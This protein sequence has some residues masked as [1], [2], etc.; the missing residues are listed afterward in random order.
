MQRLVHEALARLGF[1]PDRIH[2]E[3]MT[4]NAGVNPDYSMLAPIFWSEVS[5]ITGDRHIGLHIAEA[6]PARLLDEVVLLMYMSLDLREALNRLVRFRHLLSGGF[7][8]ALHSRPQRRDA[9]LVLDL[10]YPGFGPLRQ[11]AESVALLMVKLLALCTDDKFHL[12][13]LEFR[14][15][16]P[17]EVIEHR[18]LFGVT[19]R[20]GHAH[21]RLIFPA[22]LLDTPLPA[23]NPEMLAELER[24]A[25]DR[26]RQQDANQFL[27]KVRFWIDDHLSRP[28]LG[29]DDC[30]RDFQISR[31]ALRRNLA[32]H[33]VEFEELLDDL[34]RQRAVNMLARGD[35]IARTA[36]SIG[37]FS[38][39]DF[40]EAFQRWFGYSP[41]RFQQRREGRQT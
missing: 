6:V 31:I 33:N 17:D 16:A 13:A 24:Y 1:D 27:L 38:Y 23:A 3:A 4:R 35:S 20:F 39:P 26:L 34:R 14:H 36:Q 15:A 22:S 28:E 10:V 37:F 9:E 18:R 32:A 12:N 21:D 30:A 8:C 2:H 7:R 40:H 41:E 11:Q 5:A 25:E 29:V 19:P